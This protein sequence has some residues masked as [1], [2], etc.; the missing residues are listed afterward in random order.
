MIPHSW[1]WIHGPSWWD[2]ILIPTNGEVTYDRWI[3]IGLEF[4]VFLFFGMGN[5]AVKMYRQWLVR[6]G[7]GKILPGLLNKRDRRPSIPSET[8]SFGSRVYSSVKGKLSR[9]SITSSE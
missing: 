9:S 6:V 3:Q 7:F 4:I 5:D 1:T 8:G 2:I